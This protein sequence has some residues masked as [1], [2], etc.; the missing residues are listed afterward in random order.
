MSFWDSYKEIGGN[1]IGAEEKQVIMDEGIPLVVQEVILDEEN[2]YGPRFVAKVLVANPETGEEEERNLSFPRGTVE[3]RDRLLTQLTAYLEGEE[4][5]TVTIK[6][7]KVGRSILIRNA[8][9]DEA[10]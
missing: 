5:A 10:S 1:Y 4:G 8:N 3:S 6:L 7:E 9:P 2:Q